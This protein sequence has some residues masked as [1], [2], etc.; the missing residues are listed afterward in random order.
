ML[1]KIALFILIAIISYFF[2]EY[3]IEM[4]IINKMNNYIKNKNEKYYDDLLRYYEKNKKLK[5]KNKFNIL[6]KINILLERAQIERNVFINPITVILISIICFILVYIISF[7]FFKMSILALIIALPVLLLP[8]F[9]INLI[10]DYKIEKIEKIFLNFLLQLKNYTRINNDI[11]SAM[12]EV[13]VIEPLQSHINIFLIE[14]NSGMK[15]E[16][17]MENL[18]EKI[19]VEVFRSFFTN[20]EYCYFNG[21]DFTDLIDKS[22]KMISEIQTEKNNRIQ[23]TKSARLVLFILMFLNIFVYVTNIKN[24]YENYNIMKNTILG[25]IILYWNFISLWIMLILSNRVKKLDY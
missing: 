15:F 24:D 10:A 7:N 8:V 5:L 2:I 12:N 23:E 13:Q 21:G 25:N 14:I 11:I 3:M 17:A 1:L 4:K 22:Y 20:L 18:K 16:R 9:V 19:N 6:R